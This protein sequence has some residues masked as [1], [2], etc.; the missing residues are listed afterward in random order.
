MTNKRSKKTIT[1][2]TT[3]LDAPDLDMVRA[4]LVGL[5]ELP[6]L[7]PPGSIWDQWL[8]LAKELVERL[9]VS[10]STSEIRLAVMAAGLRAVAEQRMATAGEAQEKVVE[11]WKKIEACL[12]GM[13][14]TDLLRFLDSSTIRQVDPVRVIQQYQSEIQRHELRDAVI[15]ATQELVEF[16]AAH[17][18]RETSEQLLSS[19]ETTRAGAMVE[20]ERTGGLRSDKEVK[21]MLLDEFLGYFDSLPEAYF[22][23]MKE[24]F[25]L[26]LDEQKGKSLMSSEKNAKFASCVTERAKT[27][28]F[29]FICQGKFPDAGIKEAAVSEGTHCNVP[30][31]LRWMKKRGCEFGIFYFA[32]VLDQTAHLPISADVTVLVS[33]SQPISEAGSHKASE[34]SSKSA[35]QAENRRMRTRE[36]IHG[37]S[38]TIPKLLLVRMP[39]DRRFRHPN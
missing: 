37:Y 4:K 1:G 18:G 34:S 3:T 25:Q 30:S 12:R 31:G 9:R 28:G 35:V 17:A 26:W 6:E 15:A 38:L 14:A 8:N 16:R 11:V 27:L 29:R 10:E 7:I 22:P 2:S 13:A 24:Q 36:V 21:A 39:A 5:S 19:A 20:T 23:Q 33:G 32:H